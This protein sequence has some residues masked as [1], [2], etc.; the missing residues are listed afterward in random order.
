VC[1][2]C[3]FVFLYEKNNKSLR[4]TV[5]LVPEVSHLTRVYISLLSWN[6]WTVFR[7]RDT[8][9]LMDPNT[10]F[11]ACRSI[12]IHY[13]LPTYSPRLSH[14]FLLIFWS[15]HFC[16]NFAPYLF[17]VGFPRKIAE[18]LVEF[19]ACSHSTGVLIDPWV[20]YL[21]V[22]HVEAYTP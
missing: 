8:S 11:V 10:N 2:N 15:K 5:D 14:F 7:R 19:S 18:E 21:S 6:Q 20:Y 9:Y 22:I 3:S 16:K 13:Y 4:G 1:K 17:Q 12:E